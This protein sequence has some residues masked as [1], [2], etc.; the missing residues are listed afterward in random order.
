MQKRKI[1]AVDFDGTIVRQE[2]HAHEKTDF[3][4]MPNAKEVLS[5]MYD[6]F[7]TILWTCRD[8]LVLQN[9]VNFLSANSIQFHMINQNM[10]TIDFKTSGKI[11]ANFYFDNRAVFDEQEINWLKFKSFLTKEFLQDDEVFVKEIVDV[12]I[13][14]PVSTGRFIT[15]EELLAAAKRAKG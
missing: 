6:N 7:Y 3:V 1:I 5:W 8:G 10:P 4:L 15:E 11:F 13:A 12:V 14:E 9:A 2:E